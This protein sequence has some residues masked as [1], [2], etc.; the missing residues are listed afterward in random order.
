MVPESKARPVEESLIGSVLKNPKQYITLREI[1]SPVDF[2]TH[3]LGWA[4]KSFE[5]L[6]ERGLGID[7][8][9]VGDELA[10]KDMLEEFQFSGA[11]GRAAIAL[12]RGEGRPENAASYAHD[13]LDYSAKRKLLRER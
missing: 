8:V 9:T 13:V 4:W 10:R 6:H 3:V 11:R 12:L 7:T 1:V 2:E 5:E